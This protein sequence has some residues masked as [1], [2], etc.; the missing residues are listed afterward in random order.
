MKITKQMLKELIKEELE[1]LEEMGQPMM[2]EDEEGSEG[3]HGGG[4]EEK[5]GQ[6]DDAMNNMEAMVENLDEKQLAELMML[7]A[8]AMA[9]KQNV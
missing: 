5:E 9:D 1:N 7:A 2:P 6:S 3:K 4:P 8:E